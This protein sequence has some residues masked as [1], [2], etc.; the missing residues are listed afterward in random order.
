MIKELTELLDLISK[1]HPD[2]YT[3]ICLTVLF[4]GVIILKIIDDKKHRSYY[5]SM[6]EEKNREIE[7]LADDNRRYRDKYLSNIGFNKEQIDNMTA[8]N[9]KGE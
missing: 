1:I 4:I 8:A 2:V 9:Y 7:R 3:I 5:D 6:L